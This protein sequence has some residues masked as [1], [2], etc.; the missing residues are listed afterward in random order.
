VKHLPVRCFEDCSSLSSIIF[1]DQIE[2]IGESCFRGCTSLQ[3]IEIFLKVK[4]M[5]R[6]ESFVQSCFAECIS[7]QNLSTNNVLL[8]IPKDFE[9]SPF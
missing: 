2:S 8:F 6:I 3:S 5:V 9:D 1:H 7:L 4:K